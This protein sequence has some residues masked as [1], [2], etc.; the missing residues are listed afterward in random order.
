M[1]RSLKIWVAAGL[2][3]ALAVPAGRS[4][5]KKKKKPA[6]VRSAED[7]A[8]VDCL[9]PGQIRQLGRHFNYPTPS[10]PMRTTAVDCE[11]R[12]GDY[13]RHDRA[14]YASSLEV[15]MHEAAVG[16]PK[17]QTYVG[18]IFE[19]G[20]AGTPD[21]ELA[22]LWYRR[23]AEQG[24]ARAQRNL[25]H[26]YEQGLGVSRDREKAVEWYRKAAG[27]SDEIVLDSRAEAAAL[28]REL[29]HLTEREA[30][31][32]AELE[33]AHRD[34]AE[35][36][37][38]L[39]A[40]EEEVE[41]LRRRLEEARRASLSEVERL[42]SELERRETAAA[43]LA[44]RIGQRERQVTSQ[45]QE[46]EDWRERLQRTREEVRRG[47]GSGPTI[48]FVR[49]DV[50]TTRGPAIVPVA[51]GI[52]RLQ[53]AGQV[54]AAEGL[55]SFTVDD[56]PLEVGADGSFSTDVWCSKLPMEVRFEARDRQGRRA[57]TRLRLQT[58]SETPA[59][60]SRDREAIAAL[61]G[62]AAGAYHALIISVAHYRHLS[63]LETAAADAEEL[64]KVLGEKYGFETRVL[65]DPSKQVIYLAL[66][67]LQQRLRPEDH[68]LIYYAGH[69]RIEGEEGYWLSADADGED[70]ASWV[71]NEAVTNYLET[72]AARHI[73]VVSDSC[74]AGTFTFSSLERLGAEPTEEK[75]LKRSRT[76]LTSGGLEPVLDDV[77]GEHS[78]FAGKLLTVLKI[79][80]QCLPGDRLHEE[81]AFRVTF[82]AR[83]L[84]V[85]Q[86]PDYAPIRYAGHEAGQ[87]VLRPRGARSSECRPVS[88]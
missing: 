5:G 84:G 59:P 25:A 81:V 75:Q 82:A 10:R 21:Y 85:D 20:P 9:L 38:E 41:D 60:P 62:D 74:Y 17:A 76:A 18:E 87:F 73:L 65:K 53:V 64:K 71:P 86:D 15:W 78:L 31:A 26:L 50:L 3:L 39:A 79:N 30:R 56:R 27:I 47:G 35:A 8:V 69:G 36:R 22:A 67:D 63:D 16:D 44:D 77:G 54:T 70:P 45:E 1:R 12:G 7:L 49:P 28:R 57:S 61:P 51:P 19:K 42:E 34:L 46:A 68:L 37:K 80:D 23:A 52:E 2:T 72:I 43:R 14:S 4:L 29:E 66:A 24:L 88:R 40:A 55:A 83:G 48:R 58:P 11:I 13:A 32:R 6:E 33:A